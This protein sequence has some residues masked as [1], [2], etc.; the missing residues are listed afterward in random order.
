LSIKRKA[1]SL[2]TMVALLA[3]L[4]VTTA[5]VALANT[6]SLLQTTGTGCTPSC[7]TQVAGAGSFVAIN[8]TDATTGIAPQNGAAVMFQA[9]TGATIVGATLNFHY[10]AST[11]VSG[12]ISYIANT[13][14][15]NAGDTAHGTV[16]L[17]AT[18][19]G[20]YTITEY[21]WSTTQNTWLVDGNTYSYTF[22]SAASLQVSVA[23]SSAGTFVSCAP[24][25][26]A[27]TSGP[28]SPTNT[29]V[30]HLCVTVKDGNGNLV[31]N[32]SVTGTITP[33]GLVQVG[34]TT[35]QSYTATT[36]A[37]GAT[38]GVADITVLSSGLPGVA[39]ITV[40]VTYLAVTTALPSVSF[41]FTGTPNTLAIANYLHYTGPCD[42][43]TGICDRSFLVKATDAAGNTTELAF[44]TTGLTL[45]STP[46]GLIFSAGTA[47][48]THANNIAVACPAG[49][50]ETAYKVN[51]TLSS[52]SLTT[53]TPAVFYCNV[54]KAT[55]IVVTPAAAAIPAGGSTTIDVMAT[56]AAG[57]PIAD[58]TTIIGVASSG[59]IIGDGTGGTSGALTLGGLVTFSYFAQNTTGP[60]TV[61]FLEPAVSGVTGTGT[62]TVGTV[63]ITGT[64]G[65]HLGL[66][67]SG[68]FTSATKIQS[69]N[70][71]VTW[72]LSFG[73]VHSGQSAGI[74][75]ATKNS[76]GVWSAFTKLTGRTIDASGNAYFHWRSSTAK[77]ISIKGVVSTTGTPAR[78]ARWR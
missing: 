20:T 43:T 28:A 11:V 14:V 51:A 26:T 1:L 32:A 34:S 25:T 55:K 48:T 15:I 21:V 57:N 46:T 18:A 58:D 60:V 3:T 33:V 31:A 76:A 64:N 61:S 42:T 77:W 39:T 12:G 24:S 35:G 78:Q 36:G 54:G 13:A 9:S 53:A 74:W 52:P 66:S 44:G 69:L 37:S 19:A 7:G 62:I 40:N 30:A 6:N 67:Q 63:V 72:K 29:A 4:L 38:L 8:G 49:T 68:S 56:D 59:A 45:S 75:I 50:T 71:Y 10:Q 41:N 23:N 22:V 65:S 2:V 16:D 27:K 47:S 73:S 70:H 5:G 17:S